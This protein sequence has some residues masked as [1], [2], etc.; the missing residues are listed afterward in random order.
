M[1]SQPQPN[2]QNQQNLIEPLSDK[3][4]Q[5]MEL[6]SNPFL[7]KGEIAARLFITVG[8]LNWYIN[9]AFSKLGETDRF[10]ASWRFWE[11]YPE[12]WNKVRE[13]ISREAA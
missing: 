4:I 5:V 7:E 6:Y 10:S 13:A 9:N 3:E 8:T 1:T 12:C 11:L 2:N